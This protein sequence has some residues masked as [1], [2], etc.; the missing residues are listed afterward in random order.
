MSSF[1]FY[2]ASNGQ[3]YIIEAWMN[4]IVKVYIPSKNIAC[5]KNLINDNES[6][7]KLP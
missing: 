6:E 3:I 7:P 2:K 1:G 5:V 4:E